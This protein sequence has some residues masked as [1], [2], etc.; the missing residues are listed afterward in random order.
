MFLLCTDF[1][2]RS[3]ARTTSEMMEVDDKIM[4][5]PNFRV[6]P[7]KWKSSSSIQFTA[8]QQQQHI[9]M[10]MGPP[11]V[12]DNRSIPASRRFCSGLGSVAPAVVTAA[13]S[14]VA[15]AG[16]ARTFTPEEE[17]RRRALL[18]M[19]RQGLLITR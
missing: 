5:L 15:A 3:R 11:G 6:K 13:A 9:N 10:H 16:G 19:R 14:D 18:L 12:H 2:N 7:K 4:P 8:Q 17:R 1:L